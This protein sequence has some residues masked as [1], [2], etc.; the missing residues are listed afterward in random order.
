MLF[1]SKNKDRPFHWGP[2]ALERLP[3]DEQVIQTEAARSQLPRQQRQ[4]SD[5]TNLLGKALSKYHGIFR[6]T[7]HV[8]PLPEK[9]PVPDDLK[10]RSQDIKG[11]GYFLDASGIGICR[12]PNNVWLMNEK[13]YDH[14][15]A[16][17]IIVAHGRTPEVNNLAYSWIRGVENVAGELRAFE[18]SLALAE[19]IQWMGFSANAHDW[20]TGSVDLERL[21]VLSGLAI[22]N[23]NNI[24]NPYLG[25]KFSIAA[26]T[27]EYELYC[28]LPLG[29]GAKKAKG[30]GYMFGAGGAVPG[31]EWRRREKRPTHMSKYPLEQVDRVDRPTTLIIDNEVPKVSKRAE[32]FERAARGDLG[33]KSQ[34][35]R[36]R[37]AFKHPFAQSMVSLIKC[38]VPEQGGAPYNKVE[39]YDNPATNS[40]AVKSLSYFLGCEMT[41]IC[42]I[43]S[44]AW[45]SHNK[46]G[47][48]IEPYNKYAI[49]MLIDQGYE[50][51]EG[52]S[53]D[54]YIS[55]SQSMRAYMRGAEISG[56]MAELFRSLG[57]SSRSQTNADSDVLHVPLTLLAGLGELSRIGEVI[58]N[59]FIGPRLKTVVI[60]TDLPLLPDRPMDFGLQDFCSNCLKC[61]RECPC[62]AISLGDKVMFNGYEM[63]KPDV[64]RCTRYRLTNPKGTA[65]GRCMK[66]CP[67]NKVVTW[68]GPI[69]TRVASWCGVNL[70]WIKPFLIPLAVRLDDTMGHG[71]RNPVKKWWLDLEIVDG[72]CVLPP[73]GVNQR[74]LNLQRKLDSSRQKVAYYNA[75]VM[76]PPDAGDPVMLDRK[77]AV[78]AKELLETPEKA[79]KRIEAGNPK[80]LHY[81]PVEST[82]TGMS[83][84]QKS[85]NAIWD[86]ERS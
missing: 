8:D 71:I 5:P 27:T 61:A 52:A 75:D 21:A 7:G 62:D 79:L 73:V 53:G 46:D 26:L 68:E 36:S 65:C 48:Q 54:D 23:K 51:M 44:Y 74:D 56:I 41:G 2:Y 39:G 38:M 70:R 67:L 6:K 85:A 83:E 69:A 31:L 64:E 18:I 32:F 58:L 63:W 12:I 72:R 42:E 15:H 40:M 45:Y 17:V 34:K 29:A 37:F 30:I 55:G 49:V 20:E 1:T 35:E 59:P 4:F 81:N 19:H 24:I 3:H 13:K 60:T 84:N 25:E 10:R 14:N 11:G 57:Y 28:D 50:T 43:P 22:R 16:V 9:A 33:V 76:P 80:P 47:S 77:A 66:T 78:K 82:G 86:K